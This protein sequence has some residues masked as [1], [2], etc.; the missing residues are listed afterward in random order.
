MRD[1]SR[2]STEAVDAVRHGSFVLRC[3]IDE[4]GGVRCRLI[5]A[6]SG[7]SYPL[8]H[9]RDVPNVVQQLLLRTSAPP[10]GTPAS[11]ADRRGSSEPGV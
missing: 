2:R 8:A 9:L 1:S 3:W 6:R 5:D 11:H 10:N 7:V 4:E